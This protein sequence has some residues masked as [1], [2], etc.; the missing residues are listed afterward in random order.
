MG[1]RKKTTNMTDDQDTMTDE[2]STIVIDYRGFVG[3]ADNQPAVAHTRNPIVA[4]WPENGTME[5]ILYP[6]VNIVD[7][8]LW[9]LYSTKHGEIRRKADAGWARPIDALPDEYLLTDRDNGLIART[10]HPAGLD[11][12]EGLENAR[13]GGPRKSVVAALAEQ[14]GKPKPV[15]IEPQ[16][17]ANHA[18]FEMGAARRAPADPTASMG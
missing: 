17:W 9:R 5:L 13:P 15:F 1:R 3:S 12:I 14:R 11:W 18:V 8:D 6:G 2:P 4:S 16:P 10:R 7:A